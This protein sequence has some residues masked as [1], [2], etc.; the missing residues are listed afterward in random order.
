MDK[1][2]FLNEIITDYTLFHTLEIEIRDTFFLEKS[3]NLKSK[4]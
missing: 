3:K 1:Y 2:R 4:E